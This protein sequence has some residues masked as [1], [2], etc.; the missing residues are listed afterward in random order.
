[1]GSL[2]TTLFAVTGLLA[3]VS[4]L[5]PLA[6]RLRLPYT[7]LLA[8]VGTGLG[9][10]LQVG[11]G[12]A[13]SGAMG[14]FSDFMMAIDGLDL[15]S[16]AFL[17]I[18]LPVLLFE[19]ALSVDVRRLLDD[20]W[21]ILLLA[22]VAVL[23]CTVM[24]GLGM[25]GAWYLWYGE[26][27]GRG[28][29][30]CL[31]LASIIATTDPAAVVGIFRDLGAPRRLS[32]L[33]EG[34]S[35]FNDA[36]AIALFGL[37][38][39]MLTAGG[40]ADGAGALGSF[41]VKF[42][43]G[44]A[45]GWAM[46]R[47]VGY[48]VTPLRNQPQ[49]EITLTVALAYL[50][51]IVA[52]TYAGVSGVVAVVTA[53]LVLSHDGRT[54][55]SPESWDGLKHVWSQ[56][57]FWANSLIFLLASMLIP[58]TLLAATWGHALLLAALIVFALLARALVIYGL[59]PGLTLI[60]AADRISN[61]YKAVML[62]G[63][64]RG[65]VS[66]ALALAVTESTR[67]PAEIKELVAVVVTGFVLFTLFV[68]GTTLRPLIHLLGI[69]RLS[70][71]DLALR[72][73]ALGL[74]LGD[75]RKEVEVLARE[76][77]MDPGPALQPLLDRGADLAQEQLDLDA[78]YGALSAAERVSVGLSTLALREEELYLDYFRDGI[79]SRVIV[80]ILTTQAGRLQDAVKV[81]GQA[82]Y[83]KTAAKSTRLQ[84]SLR[85][86]LFL[87][88][89]L[90]LERPLA[91]R[92]AQRFATMAVL[93]FTVQTLLRFNRERLTPML[94]RET[95]GTLAAV[96]ERRLADVEQQLDALRLQ[97]PA[98]VEEVQ[99]RYL[100]RAGLRL[101][102][103]TLRTMFAEQVI[104][105]EIL[106][107]LERD[108]GR[109]RAAV[110]RPPALDLG[111]STT[112]LVG[113]VELFQGLPADRLGR[114]GKLLRPRLAL[115]GEVLVRQGERGDA[116]YI[117]A[118]GAVDVQLPGLSAPVRLGSG[119]VF[120]EMAL[121]FDQP[122][123]ATVVALAYTRLLVLLKKDFH[124]LS[125]EDEDLRRHINEVAARR[126]PQAS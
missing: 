11:R 17:Y 97:Y 14:P 111:L 50:A 126:L 102:E 99:C 112:E 110:E 1:M 54:R 33:V 55:I 91:R 71:V 70:P 23:I 32:I 90:G 108:L 19:T 124:T 25:W 2:V 42:A 41:F 35:L 37:L 61:P 39:A 68:Q 31:M 122:R 106:N 88:R 67:V 38:F 47:V 69:D 16:A 9:V 100:I 81:G 49:A 64:L 96:L 57:G 10:L 82:A 123:N 114:I 86:A 15:T 22:V 21:P 89:R 105:R 119:E 93:R 121:L 60:G 59:I 40:P 113:R 104:S 13:A 46:G 75:V 26:W 117:I 103:R 74:S 20:L 58:P 78:R 87:H 120:G 7:V 63:G 18:F 29:I 66:L 8:A 77:G 30:V 56:L 118:S 36:A 48:V 62:W 43:G 52:E 73:R 116:L 83:V 28:L 5:P 34:E 101:E 45:V 53:G 98:Y 51:F 12:V 94:G 4:V 85:T 6:Q 79:I 92:L 24:A 44:L 107:D 3:L 84:S 72:N 76:F 65:A 27:S 109:R 115:P 125:Q 95:G 80:Q